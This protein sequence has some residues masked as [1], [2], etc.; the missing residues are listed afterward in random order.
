M[1]LT[2]VIKEIILGNP[3]AAAQIAEALTERIG[4]RAAELLLR[5]LEALSP[6]STFQ[7][8]LLPTLLVERSTCGCPKQSVELSRNRSR[9]PAEAI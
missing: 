5:R 6:P 2:S 9:R 3:S 7:H 8:I 1:M 4:Q